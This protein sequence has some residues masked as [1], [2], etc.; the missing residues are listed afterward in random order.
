VVL[1]KYP[2]E[3]EDQDQILLRGS[4]SEEKKPIPLSNL[5]VWAAVLLKNG[6]IVNAEQPRKCVLSIRLIVQKELAIFY[7]SFKISR[8]LLFRACAVERYL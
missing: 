8:E 7:A 2:R 1:W 3:L 4:D 6:E 5:D